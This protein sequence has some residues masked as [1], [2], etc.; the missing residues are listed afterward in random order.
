MEKILC[1]FENKKCKTKQITPFTIAG[2]KIGLK[3]VY[4]NE[5]SYDDI[6]SGEVEKSLTSRFGSHKSYEGLE[7]LSFN[8]LKYHKLQDCEH[9]M[10]FN[11]GITNLRELKIT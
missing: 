5:E 9:G 4:E 7:I 2:G 6:I 3:Y 10:F 11:L 8:Q 1:N